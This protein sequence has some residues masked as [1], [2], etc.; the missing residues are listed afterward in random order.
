M[1]IAYQT[2]NVFSQA[3]VSVHYL[4]TKIC[5]MEINVKVLARDSHVEL[6]LNALQV[7]LQNVFVNQDTKGTH[8]KDVLILTNALP[9]LAHTKRIASMNEVVINV[10]VHKDGLE[11]HID[12]DVLPKN[13]QE[14][15]VT[16][17]RIAMDNWLV[18]QE[19]VSIPAQQCHVGPT[20][21]ANLTTTIGLGASAKLVLS[22]DPM[23]NAYLNVMGFTAGR[24]PNVSSQPMVQHV[25]A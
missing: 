16:S 4:S 7:I 19:L 24:V 21:I 17:T 23:E 9:N 5:T 1:E 8:I 22:K 18:W 12:Q 15:N 10:F 25:N 6:T 11:I 20:P 14:L 13:Q 3:N 2:K